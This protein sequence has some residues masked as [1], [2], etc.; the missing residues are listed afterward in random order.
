MRGLSGVLGDIAVV[1]DAVV[2]PVVDNAPIA[3]GEGHDG[4]AVRAGH[5]HVSFGELA[6]KAAAETVLI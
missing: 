3:N 4:V 5:V 6:A 2:E 1:L